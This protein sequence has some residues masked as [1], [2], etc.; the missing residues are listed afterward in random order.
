MS[1][2][3]NYYILGMVQFII[4]SS[5]H[6]LYRVAKKK[7]EIWSNIEIGIIRMPIY[8]ILIYIG[9]KNEKGIKIKDIRISIIYTLYYN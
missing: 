2:D 4:F 3:V 6:I 7:V 9:S 8:N 1:C 5:V